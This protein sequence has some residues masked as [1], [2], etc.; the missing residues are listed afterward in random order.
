VKVTRREGVRR[1]LPGLTTGSPSR[2]TVKAIVAEPIIE[3]RLHSDEIRYSAA[4][5]TRD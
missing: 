3:Y 1:F 5:R 2:K 4:P